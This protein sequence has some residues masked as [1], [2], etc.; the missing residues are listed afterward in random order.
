MGSHDTYDVRMV[1]AFNEFVPVY[2]HVLT[3]ETMSQ[4]LYNYQETRYIYE[5]MQGLHGEKVAEEN[6]AV[7]IPFIIK[8]SAMIDWIKMLSLQK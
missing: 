6:T 2:F 7:L 1:I 5:E 3:D 8:L 4:I